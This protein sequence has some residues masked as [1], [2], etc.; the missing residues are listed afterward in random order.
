M[1]ESLQSFSFEETH[2]ATRGLYHD[3]FSWSFWSQSTC[4]IVMLSGII[5]ENGGMKN[6]K[7][8]VILF[9]ADQT[10]FDF[11]KSEK[12]ALEKTIEKLGFL[13]VEEK[14]LTL[15]HDVNKKIWKE[16]EEGLITQEKLKVERFHRF[17]ETMA[18]D[19]S[20]EEF[21]EHYME[22]LSQASF[23]YDDAL[24]LIRSLKE[25][26]KLAIITNGLTRVQSKRIKGSIL[27]N[28]FEEIIISEEIQISK[29]NPEIFEYTLKKLGQ[30]DKNSVLMVGDSLTSDIR[31][32]IL[33]GIDTCWYNPNKEVNSFEF[34]P[35]YEILQLSELW[36]FL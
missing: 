31:G 19:F 33:F 6:M 28:Y 1:D 30:E 25:H 32:G 27:A 34:T 10:L 21:A 22:F 20:P 17:K 12:Y 15:Y 9:D 13:Y 7:Y 26:Y 23:I 5:S 35:T 11:E 16:F 24:E 4:I 8:D 18:W 29:P 14:H 2:F 3:K 36:R